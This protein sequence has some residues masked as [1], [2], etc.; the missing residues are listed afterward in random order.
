MSAQIALYKFAGSGHNPRYLAYLFETILSLECEC[1]PALKVARLINWVVNPSGLPGRNVEGDLVQE[2]HIKPLT[3]HSRRANAAYDGDFER[4]VLSPNLDQLVALSRRMEDAVGLMSRSQKHTAMHTKPEL[5]K[6]LTYYRRKELHRFCVGRSYGLTVASHY[7]RGMEQM[8][9][10]LQKF[11]TTYRADNDIFGGIWTAP[12][13]AAA[14]E[15]TEAHLSM[16]QDD[17]PGAVILEDGQ[18]VAL[19]LE[20]VDDFLEL[21]DGDNLHGMDNEAEDGEEADEIPPDEDLDE[22]WQGGDD[23]DDD[24]GDSEEMEDV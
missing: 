2:H 3:S 22:L 18:L 9:H 23:D 19:E 17:T 20:D 15:D 13:G 12:D 6:L 8:P 1:S 5:T 14:D 16:A 7:A 24:E 4:N 21:D 10:K 11:L